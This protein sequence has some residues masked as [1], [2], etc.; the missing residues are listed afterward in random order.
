MW[1]GLSRMR[2]RNVRKRLPNYVENS[3][4]LRYDN[5]SP[6]FCYTLKLPKYK[7]RQII[8][9]LT[10][11]VSASQRKS[12]RR[13]ITQSEIDLLPRERDIYI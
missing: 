8:A 6:G 13:P 4:G 12:A 9:T 5:R 1:Q 2:K 11:S 7:D 3:I 10:C